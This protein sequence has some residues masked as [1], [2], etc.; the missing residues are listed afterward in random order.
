MAEPNKIKVEST[1]MTEPIKK[2]RESANLL[3]KNFLTDARLKDFLKQVEQQAN[4]LQQH[5]TKVNDL[6]QTR[7]TLESRLSVLDAKLLQRERELQQ[8]KKQLDEQAAKLAA[9]Q[10]SLEEIKVENQKKGEELES[11]KKELDEKKRELDIKTEKILRVQDDLARTKVDL[12]LKKAQL[13]KETDAFAKESAEFLECK[14]EF[15]KLQNKEM[16]TYTT[17]DI[18]D[19]LN[20]TINEFNSNDKSDSNEAKYIINNMDVDL[21][22]RICND[23]KKDNGKQA[24]KFIAPS[25]RETTEDSL[26]SIKISIQAVPK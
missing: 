12:E 23:G 3:P 9:Q 13:E 11:T 19:F 16:V 22:V 24:I 7:K 6:T 14:T 2:I 17:E 18:S 15:E 20:K 1:I 8:Q 10:K 25:I 5:I 21:K 26:S 4:E